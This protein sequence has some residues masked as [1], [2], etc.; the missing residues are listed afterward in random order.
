MRTLMILGMFVMFNYGEAQTKIDKTFPVKQGQKL[1]LSFDYPNKIRVHTWDKNEVSISGTASINRGENDNAFDIT[2][3]VDGNTVTITSTIKDK[4]NLP[5]HLIIKAGDQEYFFKSKSWDDPEVQKFLEDKGGEYSYMSH[6][7]I[8]EIE[9]EVY[10][11][12]G[13]ETM[14]SAKYGIVEVT[15]FVSSLTIEA[16]YGGIDATV[17]AASTGEL[18]ARTRYGEILTNLDVKFDELWTDSKSNKWTEISSKPG[19]GA[20][21][22][23]ESKYGNVYLRKPK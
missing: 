16:K 19:R 17:I 5:Q 23:F 21:Y 3:T 11:P 6:G 10:V 7:V 9:L 22:V 12:K 14:I 20:T 1:V 15:N 13:V 18:T 4:E 2:S 8:K